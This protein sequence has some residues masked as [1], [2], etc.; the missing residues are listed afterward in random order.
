M[1][2][3]SL[4]YALAFAARLGETALLTPAIQA[5]AD[6]LLSRPAYQTVTASDPRRDRTIGDEA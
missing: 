3:I 1:A 6:R 5:Y 2:D 4:G